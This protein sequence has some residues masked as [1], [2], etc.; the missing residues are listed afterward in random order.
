LTA[1][2]GGRAIASV[3][4]TSVRNVS[5][6]NFPRVTAIARSRSSHGIESIAGNTITLAASSHNHDR[7]PVASERLDGG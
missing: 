2:A 3:V 6:L 7:K 4:S 1:E 5:S